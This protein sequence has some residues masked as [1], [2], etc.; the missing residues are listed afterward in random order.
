MGSSL[1]T[2]RAVRHRMR[3]RSAPKTPTARMNRGRWRESGRRRFDATESIR[4]RSLQHRRAARSAAR[5]N[6]AACRPDP[7][8]ELAGQ[9][10]AHTASRRVPTI[11]RS[12]RENQRLCMGG[13]AA[14]Y[15]RWSA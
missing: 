8:L 11:S 15:V 9:S 12:D 13:G 6:T 4:E 14:A 10:A 5:A 7:G 3:A 2:N 1:T